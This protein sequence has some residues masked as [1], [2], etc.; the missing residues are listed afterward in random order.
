MRAVQDLRA[1]LQQSESAKDGLQRQI[2]HLEMEI[3]E[4][5]AVIERLTGV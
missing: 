4:L 2:R 1:A 3:A 5:R